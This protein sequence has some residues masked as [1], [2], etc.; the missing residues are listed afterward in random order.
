M[1]ARFDHL[2]L[3][4]TLLLLGVLYGLTLPTEITLEDAGIFQMACHLGGISHP[5]GYP[6]FTSLCQVLVFGDTVAPGNLIST[7]F[8][9]AAVATFYFVV[10]E[11]S[12]DQLL[13]VLSALAYGLTRCLWSQALIIEVYSLAAFLFL[14]AWLMVLRFVHTSNIKYWYCLSFVVGLGLSNHWPLF[15]L[16]G[17]GFLP[18][19]V[20]HLD[21]F[22]S[23]L[24]IQTFFLSLVCLLIGLSPYL[25]LFQADPLIAIY[26]P[27]SSEN[28]VPYVLREYYTDNHLDARWSDKSEYLL[29][30]VPLT[31]GQLGWLAA[32]LIALGV[33]LAEKKLQ[34]SHLISLLL[35]YAASTFL[36]A[37]MLNFR[38]EVQYQAIFYPYPVIAMAPVACFFAVGACWLI[39]RLNTIH[40]GYGVSVGVLLILGVIG[41]NYSVVDRSSSRISAEYAETVLHMMP[42]DAVLFVEG[43]SQTGPIGF[44]S[45]VQNKRPDV[46]VQSLLGLL[47]RDNIVQ[48]N[49]SEQERLGHLRDYAQDS[50]RP[51]FS[52]KRLSESDADYGLFFEFQG[53]GQTHVILPA[54]EDF[55]DYILAINEGAFIREPHERVL[56]NELLIKLS[57]LYSEVAVFRG[58]DAMTPR[59][60]H[61]LS[62]LQATFEGKLLSLRTMV[63]V[64]PK[65][66]GLLELGLVL[67][68]QIDG[69]I[70]KQQQALVYELIGRIMLANGQLMEAESYFY[71]SAKRRPLD[72]NAS[73][74]EFAR[75]AE[76]ATHDV[77]FVDL[78]LDPQICIS[79]GG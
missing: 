41:N 14:F 38:F 6:L 23:L 20:K 1:T 75:L 49:W 9:P 64:N 45:R 71:R 65:A 35:V 18:L 22:L 43:D 72:S 21:K 34:L 25:T 28:F 47:F 53:S 67:E 2:V 24:K 56:L 36:L 32:P 46:L 44:V 76:P 13:A 16:S 63:A 50:P 52:M 62:R 30:M 29:W 26:G 54:V 31:F 42:E 69:A 66:E 77:V 17:V 33:L 40:S 58:M 7:F 57:R 55:A 3:V 74:C 12:R 15:V 59:Q 48:P 70:S 39:R 78:K 10:L 11:L 5:P 19:I 37:A 27:V 4:P 61:T 8:A 68:D 73:V 79:V 60:Q 51:V